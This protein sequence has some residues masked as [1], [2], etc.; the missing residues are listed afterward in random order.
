MSTR[1]AI[2]VSGS[3]TNMENIAQ[4]IQAGRLKNCEIAIV[5]SDKPGVQS[6]ER[7][8]KLKLKSTVID[9]RKLA[10]KAAFE[11]AVETVLQAEKVDLI[12]LAGFMCVL[13]SAFVKAHQ[14]K[15]INIH[16][17]LLPSFPGANGIRDAWEAHVKE[18]GVS[19]HFVD[20]GVDTGPI[21]LQRKLEVQLK[22][23]LESLEERLHKIEYALYPEALQLVIDG[24]IQL[25]DG[26]AIKRER[27]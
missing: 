25:K 24:K 16:P 2:L 6:L 11:C 3:G 12:V 22:E 9:R 19:V 20:E 18:T 7:A 17:A 4:Y 5:I 23:S 27:N 1:L 21:I 10:S 26:K 15:I 13:S 14:G 8:A